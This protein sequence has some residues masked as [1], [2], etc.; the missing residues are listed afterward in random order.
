[1]K[2]I[3]VRFFLGVNLYAEIPVCRIRIAPDTAGES[4]DSPIPAILMKRS[5]S[6]FPK[7]QEIFGSLRKKGLED[8]HFGLLLLGISEMTASG[9]E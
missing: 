6:A 3:E 2:I 1:M 8:V 4:A 9:F 7:L 5:L